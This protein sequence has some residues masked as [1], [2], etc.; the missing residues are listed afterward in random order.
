[1]SGEHAVFA[2]VAGTV[3]RR[4]GVGVIGF[5]W[6]GQAHSRSLQRIPTL[7]EQR[8]FDPVLVACSDTAA[9]AAYEQAI[10]SFGFKRGSEQ[11]AAVIDDPEVDVVFIAAPNMF[12]IELVQ[13]VAAVGKPVFCEKPVGGRPA[14][15]IVAS[16]A[17]R[18]AGVIS[19]VGDNYRWAP[20]VQLRARADRQRRAGRDH[21]VTERFFFSMYGA[22]PLGVNS[23]RFQ[24]NQAG[25]GVT[26]DLLSHAVDLAQMLLGPI[27]S[28]RSAQ[29]ET[30]IRRAPGARP[31]AAS[32]YGRG[33]PR[34][35]GAG[36][37]RGLRRDA[38]ALCRRRP[39][40]LRGEPD[41]RRPESPDGIRRLRDAG[42]RR[43]E[44]RAAQRVAAVPRRRR[45][46]AR[47]TRPC[48]AATGSDITGHS[49]PA[50]ATRSTYEDLV[51][52]EDYE[53]CSAVAAGA[54]ISTRG[55]TRRW[56]GRQSRMRCCARIRVVTGRTSVT[57]SPRTAAAGGQLSSTATAVAPVRIGVIGAGRIGSMHA[58][59]LTHRVR[60]RH[61]R[62]RVR[63][64]RA[65]SRATSRE[66]LHVPDGR[67]RLKRCWPMRPTRS[68]SARLP[69]P[70]WS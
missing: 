44:P 55:L 38:G 50:A 18:A 27:T 70:T 7:F 48:S 1:M 35:G 46:V 30:F 8:N 3:R 51:A 40:H 29:L 56:N 13:A 63:R 16:R 66:R 24:L 62:R 28:G 12:H 54:A 45:T 69:T 26:S 17:A 52:I 47:A 49:R 68:R 6:L 14:D 10:D 39:R 67:E 58:E 5:G 53:F 34:P 11:W 65:G 23:W 41:D 20:L 36:H 57:C 15:V 60:G 21:Q 33:S 61:R 4:L 25:Y 2:T 64:A 9:R 32:H 22:D 37:Q 19:G 43:V 42:G 31:A 59:L